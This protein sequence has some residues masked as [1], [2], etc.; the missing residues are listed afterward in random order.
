MLFCVSPRPAPVLPCVCKTF[1]PRIPTFHLP[2]IPEGALV[3][4]LLL[5]GYYIDVS[6]MRQ[7][8]AYD[9]VGLH[10]PHVLPHMPQG[11]NV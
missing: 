8:S 2:T 6:C 11:N 5:I 3:L 4:G 1:L 10:Q 9:L 7:N